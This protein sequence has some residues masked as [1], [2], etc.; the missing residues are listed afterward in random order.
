MGSKQTKTSTKSKKENRKRDD[1]YL[2]EFCACLSKSLDLLGY[3]RD[4]IQYRR[5]KNK[6]LDDIHNSKGFSVINV[7]AG[8]KG[9]GIALYFESDIDRL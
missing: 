5:D 2:K 6:H 8:G 9:E 3:S 7:T 1:I 4:M